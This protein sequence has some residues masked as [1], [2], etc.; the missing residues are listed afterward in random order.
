MSF[1]FHNIAFWV[2]RRAQLTPARTA[3][4]IGD[5]RYTYQELDARAARAAGALTATGVAVGDRVA[6]LL[7]NSVAYV[8]VMLACAR[9]GAICVPLSTRLT[10]AELEFI[11]GDSQP[12]TLITGAAFAATAQQLAQASAIKSLLI[13]GGDGPESFESVCAQAES[14]PVRDLGADDTVAIIY[15]SGTTGRPKGAMLTHGN[16]FWTN[17]NIAIALDMTSDERSLMVLPMF[18]IGGWNVNTLSVWWKGGCVYVEE[19]FDAQ[20]ALHL[21]QQER[22]TSVMGV[23]TIYQMLA[24]HPAFASTDISSVRTFVCGGAPLP[25]SLIQQYQQRG[26]SFVQG[27]GLTEA[28]PNC[29]ILPAEDS[30]RKAGAAGR[31][32]FFA[33]VR[34]VDAD[35]RD[36][37]AGETGEIIVG[38]PSVMKGYWGLPQET[39]DALRGGWL[40]T[41]D[42]GLVD[43]EGTITI[44]DRVKDMYISGG[45]NVYPAEV[46]KTLAGHPEIAEAAV[47]GVSDERWGEAGLAIVVLRGDTAADATS[48]GRIKE[49]C[50][51][52]L[53]K[54]K[55]PRDVVF[56]DSLP[57]NSTGK[58]LKTE[59]RAMHLHEGTP[60]GSS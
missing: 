11:V 30:V 55:V 39:A 42:V 6:A 27:Y 18:H 59:L 3:L 21:I 22:I 7:P 36:V 32:Y 4:V 50:A 12:H 35:D 15:T 20:R 47:I 43:G 38:G 28:A 26:A 52:R 29:L 9:L 34:V 45:E 37:A 5:A 56:T 49:F 23:P 54:F 24:E 31:P 40:R 19:A 13:S 46:E 41:G 57:R 48:A 53:A 25:V 51:E 1:A 17:L 10:S 44:V 2:A 8:D 33:D 60:R 58:L 14:E 16:F